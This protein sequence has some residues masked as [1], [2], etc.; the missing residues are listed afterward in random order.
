MKNRR[1]GWKKRDKEGERSYPE[2]KRNTPVWKETLHRVDQWTKLGPKGFKPLRW[3]LS[4]WNTFSSAFSSL[5]SSISGVK[6][7]RSQLTLEETGAEKKRSKT[8]RQ[9]TVTKRPVECYVERIYVEKKAEATK[10]K[11]ELRRRVFRSYSKSP[12][13]PAAI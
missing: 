2:K 7:P 3:L 11:V 5:R 12:G 1:K 13:C 6:M 4:A 9:D 8:K 10:I